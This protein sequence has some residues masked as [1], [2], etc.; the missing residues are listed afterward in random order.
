MSAFIVSTDHIDAIVT[1]ATTKGI[2]RRTPTE[3]GQIL[4]AENA[5]SVASRYNEAVS[6]EPAAYL[7]RI[8]IKPLSAVAIL[9]A[10]DCLEYQSCEHDGWA[11]SVAKSILDSI[12]VEAIKK[13]PGYADAQWEVNR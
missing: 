6:N 3:L 13:L 9:K 1:Y 7:Y 8:F 10:V 11:D 12:R 5:R 4:L 2:S